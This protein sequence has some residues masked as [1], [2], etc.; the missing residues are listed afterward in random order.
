MEDIAPRLPDTPFDGSRRAHAALQSLGSTMIGVLADGASLTY[1][2]ETDRVQLAVAAERVVIAEIFKSVN[3]FFV[4]KSS[5]LATMQ[6]GQSRDLA[7]LY[8]ALSELAQT[9]LAG[10][11]GD[12]EDRRLPS[13]LRQY[14]TEARDAAGHRSQS[15]LEAVVD[16]AVIDYICSLRDV[17]AIDLAARLKGS[18]E[19]MT[20]A[21]R[22]LDT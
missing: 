4:V 6:H 1:N 15:D 7:V 16:I 13:R 5:T 19:A 18:R 9:W 12:A 20:I 3:I 17:Q 10:S 8:S 22:W 14:I 2:N 21:S 11:E